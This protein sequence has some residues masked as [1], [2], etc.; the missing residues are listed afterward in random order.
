MCVCVH[1]SALATGARRASQIP[2]A[3]IK[4]IWG[5]LDW[6]VLGTKLQSYTRTVAVTNH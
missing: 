1:T 6:G 3:G 5:P 4:E 2:L